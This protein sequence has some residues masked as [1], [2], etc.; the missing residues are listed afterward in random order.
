MVP[1]IPQ[2]ESE[3]VGSPALHSS[4]FSVQSG[5][6]SPFLTQPGQFGFSFRKICQQYL[7]G[8][9]L[10]QLWTGSDPVL[11]QLWTE[12]V[13]SVSDYQEVKLP[14]QEPDG[15]GFPALV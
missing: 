7:A 13:I 11:C 2:N 15:D 4:R 10:D 8:P 14:H 9:A 5:F 1:E 3:T 12:A 6:M